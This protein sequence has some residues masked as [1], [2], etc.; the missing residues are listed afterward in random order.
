MT[1]TDLKAAIGGL[2]LLAAVAAATSACGRVGSLEPPPGSSAATN[3]SAPK[4]PAPDATR[5]GADPLPA[6]LTTSGATRS[7]DGPA[8]DNAP[9]TK[10]DIQDPNQRLTPLSTRP[11]D[12]AP[13]PFGA[14]VSTR[15]PG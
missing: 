14:P 9:I 5:R 12:G 10:R 11:V 2:A 6:G 13:N 8:E 15:P 4:P 7:T 3:P 1:R